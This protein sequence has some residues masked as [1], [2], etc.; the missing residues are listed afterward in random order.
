[1]NRV[2]NKLQINPKK[3]KI[4][5]NVRIIEDEH[6]KFVLKK[7]E[8]KKQD[9]YKYLQS[10]N[11]G[12]VPRVYTNELDDYDVLEYINEVD[13]LEEQKL[14]DMI[15][16]LT[17]MHTKTTFYKEVDLDEIKKIYEDQVNYLS[18]LSS[19]YNDLN[20]VIENET[21]MSPSNY[22][23][24][25]NITNIYTIINIGYE[26]V[27][28]WYD[29]VKLKKTLRYT[30]NHNNLKSSHVLEDSNNIYFIN[31]KNSD[32]GFNV[33][34][35]YSIYLNNFE[36]IELETIINLYDSKYKLENYEYYYLIASLCNI[37]KLELNN[38]LN[39]IKETYLLLEYIKGILKYVL[40]D[41][42]KK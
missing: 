42:S 31:W 8:K 22:L 32:F 3:I 29:E 12:N 36:N 4:K 39:G 27:N 1:M 38:G 24:I 26:Y 25:R 16:L 33:N 34:D 30:L 41:N 20:S 9:I 11:F 6:N 15:Y 35:L 28:K 7:N 18:Y 13:I 14:T 5:N 19:Y 17:I 40:K 37:K 2:L 23:L 21:Y 10:R